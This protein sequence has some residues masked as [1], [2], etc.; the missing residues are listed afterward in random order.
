MHWLRRWF[1]GKT[2]GCDEGRGVGRVNCGGTGFDFFV[3]S[4][5]L[6][7]FGVFLAL[8][9]FWKICLLADVISINPAVV[10]SGTL[11]RSAGVLIVIVGTLERLLWIYSYGFVTLENISLIFISA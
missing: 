1:E 6:D 9:F 11:G 2:Q 10:I 8:L 7:T 5:C 3:I 4:G